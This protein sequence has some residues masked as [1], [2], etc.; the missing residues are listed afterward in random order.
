MFLSRTATTTLTTTTTL[1]HQPLLSSFRIVALRRNLFNSSV[2][3]KKERHPLYN[4]IVPRPLSISAVCYS[5]HNSFPTFNWREQPFT[6]T[7]Q[8]RTMSTVE[9]SQRVVKG[10][11]TYLTQKEAQDIDVELMGPLSFSIG[12]TALTLNKTISDYLTLLSRSAYGTCRFECGMFGRRGLPQ[13][14]RRQASGARHCRPWKYPLFLTSILTDY[15]IFV[16]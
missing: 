7:E 5:H 2:S 3:L 8:K 6:R 12:S 14:E 11:V 15:V 9:S 16:P 13:Q 1:T 10:N 4:V